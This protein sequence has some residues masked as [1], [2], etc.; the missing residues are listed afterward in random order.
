MKIPA[1]VFAILFISGCQTRESGVPDLPAVMP[2][3]RVESAKLDVPIKKETGEILEIRDSVRQGVIRDFVNYLSIGKQVSDKS[4]SLW[5]CTEG[6][7]RCAARSARF[8]E[9]SW[10]YKY[11]KYGGL[12]DVEKEEMFV[13]RL[14]NFPQ[15]RQYASKK[16][17]RSI[18]DKG[19]GF[20]ITFYAESFDYYQEPKGMAEA[21]KI[22][23]DI[24]RK[25]NV[26]EC[27]YE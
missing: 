21:E 27:E 19:F 5:R 15:L 3:V 6:D 24:L 25:N 18:A 20:H 1:F 23:F 22:F 2:A 17:N 4:N 12:S 26:K 11:C 10:W 7:M 8:G 13:N 9:I 14:K 16:L